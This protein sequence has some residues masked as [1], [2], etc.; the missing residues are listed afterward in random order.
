MYS[1]CV[2]TKLYLTLIF[3]CEKFYK[4]FPGSS[5]RLVENA[6]KAETPVQCLGQEDLLEKG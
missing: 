5:A 6:C 3:L 1:P 2:L 4:G